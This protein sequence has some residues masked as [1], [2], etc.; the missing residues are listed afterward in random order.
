MAEEWWHLAENKV[1]SSEVQFELLLRLRT[2]VSSYIGVMTL[3]GG[4]W[5]ASFTDRCD[6]TCVR[7][8]RQFTKLHSAFPKFSIRAVH[9]LRKIDNTTLRTAFEMSRDFLWNCKSHRHTQASK[10]E[11]YLRPF[12]FVLIKTF[13]QENKL[14]LSSVVWCVV[15]SL[16][17]Q[18]IT[19]VNL[20][21]NFTIFNC[22]SHLSN[23]TKWTRNVR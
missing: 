16:L 10:Y 22:R 12:L 13:I 18:F 1:R 4:H 9:G 3:A 8:A 23:T 21:Q 7:A 20:S 14:Y 6:R 17:G 11:F 19:S 15:V 2:G 5:N